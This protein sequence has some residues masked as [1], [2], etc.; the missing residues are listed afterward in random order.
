MLHRKDCMKTLPLLEGAKLI[1]IDE[2]LEAIYARMLIAGW[3]HTW[4]E[5]DPNYDVHLLS[6]C[7]TRLWY[8]DEPK[9]FMSKN[10]QL[11]DYYSF[12]NFDEVVNKDLENLTHILQTFTSSNIVIVDCLSSLAL[13]VGLAKS[14]WF[15]EKLSKQVSQLI[16]I[17]KR[18]FMQTNIPA[19]ETLGT[20][21][22]KLEKCVGISVTNN[23]VYSTTLV[24]RKPGGSL[25]C[26]KEI[27]TQNNITYQIISGS[28]IT[29]IDHEDQTNINQ[30][31]KIESSFRI[32][33]NAQE[34]EQRDRTPL[35]YMM[36]AAS[37]SKI[38]YQPDDVDD[39]DEDDPDDD[40]CI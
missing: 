23:L 33:M 6:F 9:P 36:N 3:M 4:S 38:H 28:I 39:I 40:L 31:V 29:P 27:I 24:H 15:I 34:M 30:P 37:T 22:V 19:I 26:Q 2:G 14:L 21:Y 7:N 35:P 32:E 8:N 13:Y 18:D 25:L 12:I 5:K 10:M 20:T 16:C 1:V 17:Y 11:H